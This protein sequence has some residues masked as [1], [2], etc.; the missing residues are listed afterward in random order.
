MKSIVRKVKSD[1]ENKKD[2]YQTN[3][4]MMEALLNWFKEQKYDRS[5]KVL[6]PCCGEGVISEALKKYFYNVK[7]YDKYTG[8]L[9]KDFLT[10]LNSY[11]LIVFNPPYS[12]KYDFINHARNIATE[13][14]CLLPLNISNYNMFHRDYEDVT[15]FVGKLQMAPKMFLDE[16]R[17]YR[18]GGNS[19]YCWY[20]WN[21]NNATN[22]SLTWYDDLLKYKN[23]SENT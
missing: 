11:D 14:L 12:A 10:E 18:P 2:F 1:I 7:S 9:K 23:K 22:Y 19:Q 4:Y 3:P 5:L 21:K 8:S 20:Q 15:Q 16:T 17:D 6:D 13:V